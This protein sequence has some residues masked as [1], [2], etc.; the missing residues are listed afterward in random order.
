MSR[1]E[2]LQRISFWLAIAGGALGFLTSA[3]CSMAPA[4]PVGWVNVLH[5]MLLVIGGLLGYFSVFRTEEIDRER[6]RI[7]EDSSLTSGERD[8]AHRFA[9]RQRRGAS[10]AFLAAPLMLGYWMAY[11]VEGEGSELAAQLLPVTAVLGSLTGLLIARSKVAA[12][13]RGKPD[14]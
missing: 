9:E 1:L 5:P 6:W 4:I 13:R 10:T 7:A 12:T 14:D 11:Q 3:G 8:Y 2:R